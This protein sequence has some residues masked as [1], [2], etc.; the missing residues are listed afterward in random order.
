MKVAN[1]YISRH[2]FSKRKFPQAQE[3]YP[4]MGNVNKNVSD[5]VAFST[6]STSSHI[7]VNHVEQHMPHTWK[8]SVE[9]DCQQF[10]LP[11]VLVSGAGHTFLGRNWLQVVQLSWKCIYQLKTVNNHICC[12]RIFIRYPDFFK[13]KFG[14]LKSF[15]TALSV[16]LKMKSIFYKAWHVP[17]ALGEKVNRETDRLQSLGIIEPMQ[18]SE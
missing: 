15:T 14:K 11:L 5:I 18:Y 12:E 4:T 1:D 17:F 3:I 6:P 13:D 10:C 8:V 7:K 16:V 2:L 9:Y